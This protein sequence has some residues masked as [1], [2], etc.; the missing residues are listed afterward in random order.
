MLTA[1]CCPVSDF[2][3]RDTLC[4]TALQL[5]ATCLGLH[6]PSSQPFGLRASSIPASRR[7]VWTP[8]MLQLENLGM[9]W[10]RVL[11]Q[12]RLGNFWA[13]SDQNVILST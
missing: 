4:N 6:I 2:P 11:H 12:E 13:E 9:F 7:E 5:L 1:K 3:V 8:P 10:G